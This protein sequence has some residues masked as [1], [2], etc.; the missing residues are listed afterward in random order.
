[1]LPL[2]DADATVELDL[3]EKGD[4]LKSQL[5][6]TSHHGSIDSSSSSFLDAMTPEYAVIS[7]DKNNIRGYPSAEIL[8]RFAERNII[9]L[10]TYEQGNITFHS[11]GKTLTR[12]P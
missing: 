8:K 10:T 4:G 2:G 7:I 3:L 12:I 11:D 5:V 1:M 9:T 6:K